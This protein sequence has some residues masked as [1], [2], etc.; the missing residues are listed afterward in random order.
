LIETTAHNRN[1]DFRLCFPKVSSERV[2]DE[3]H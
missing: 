1:E 2:I 3:I